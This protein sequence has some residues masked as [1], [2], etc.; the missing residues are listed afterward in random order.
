M[1][2]WPL[3]LGHRIY[4]GLFH[5]RDM[6]AYLSLQLGLPKHISWPIYKHMEVGGKGL[7]HVNVYIYL[8]FLKFF[9]ICE[10]I[11]TGLKV[12]TIFKIF[13]IFQNVTKF[14][15][16]FE[17]FQNSQYSHNLHQLY[18]WCW[19]T[20]I[21]GIHCDNLILLKLWCCLE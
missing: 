17:I 21:R 16:F 12:S 1:Q 6:K 3:K 19:E 11:L 9:E 10:Q 5:D 18:V 15:T 4:C 20:H 2:I 7:S 8:K 14:S 13:K